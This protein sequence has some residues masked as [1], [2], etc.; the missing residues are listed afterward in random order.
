MRIWQCCQLCFVFCFMILYIHSQIEI[1]VISSKFV[2]TFLSRLRQTPGE[3]TGERMVTSASLAGTMSVRLKH[4]WS[5]C[6]AG[7]RWRTC[8]T[9]PTTTITADTS[10]DTTDDEP[11]RNLCFL[12]GWVSEL[13]HIPLPTKLAG[14]DRELTPEP[15]NPLFFLYFSLLWG[16]K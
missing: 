7:S 5:V 13:Q 11:H 10:R 8:T 1:C 6:G 3:R 9:F 15:L 14:T 12:G 4:L 2:C 16:S